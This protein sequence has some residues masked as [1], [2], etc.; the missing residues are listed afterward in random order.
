L[1]GGATGTGVAVDAASRGL[2][3]ALVERDDYGSGTSSRSTKLVHGGVRYLE[4]AF[5]KLDYSQFLLV[6][7]ALHERFVYLRN[8][9]HLTSALPIMLPLYSWWTAPYYWVGTH[10]YDL[11]SGSERLAS[12]YFVNKQRALELFPMLNAK[13][14]CGAMVFFDGQTND[15]RMNIALALTSVALGATAVNHA[16]VFESCVMEGLWVVL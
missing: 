4:N 9:P 6:K 15:S 12:S 10:V 13:N 11:V 3:V 2:K 5:K 7:E 16:E 14:L 1:Q 8:A